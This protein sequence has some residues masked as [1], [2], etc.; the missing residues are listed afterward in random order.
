MN[1]RTQGNFPLHRI[2]D[3][4][5]LLIAFVLGALLAGFLFGHRIWE[6]GIQSLA[7]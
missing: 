1:L 3:P 6:G 2:F 5:L 4:V 7:L